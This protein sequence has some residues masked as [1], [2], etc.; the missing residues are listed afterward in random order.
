MPKWD[1]TLTVEK[2]HH[3]VE[4]IGSKPKAEKDQQKLR[5]Y[6]KIGESLKK[7]AKTWKRLPKLKKVCYYK[8]YAI[9]TPQKF[10]AILGWGC[11]IVILRTAFCCQKPF[12]TEW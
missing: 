4:K 6:T 5:Q 2:L 8:L 7:C 1:S 3:K 12:L 11:V 9:C 10:V